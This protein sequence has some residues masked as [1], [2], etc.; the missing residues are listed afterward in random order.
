MGGWKLRILRACVAALGILGWAT[1]ASAQFTAESLSDDD[2]SQAIALLIEETM[3]DWDPQTHWDPPTPKYDHS[4]LGQTPLTILGLMHAGVKCQDPRLQPSVQWMLTASLQN[5]Y[6]V[7]CRAQAL[8]LMP[9][10]TRPELEQDIRWL[11]SSFGNK[12]ACWGY[13]AQPNTK[14]VDNSLR[15]YGALALWAGEQRGVQVPLAVWAALEDHLLREQRTDGGWGYTATDA[16][17]SSMTLAALTILAIAQ[18][19]LHSESAVRGNREALQRNQD[20]LQRGLDWVDQHFDPKSN[21]SVEKGGVHDHGWWWYH[22]YCVERVALATGRHRFGSH[23]WY[24]AIAA[25]MLELKFQR[26]GKKLVRNRHPLNAIDR[27]FALMFLSRGR[28]PVAINKLILDPQHTNR[29]PRD[30][31]NWTEHLVQTTEEK[32]NWQCVTLDDPL[33]KWIQSPL[34]W[35]TGQGRILQGS[36]GKSGQFQRAAH[37]HVAWRER[38]ARG[39]FPNRQAFLTAQAGLP[40]PPPHQLCQKMQAYLHDGGLLVASSDQRDRSFLASVRELGKKIYP[41]ASWETL[42][43]DHWIYS[44]HHKVR[45][46]YPVVEALSPGGRERILLFPNTDVSAALQQRDPHKVQL[47]QTLTNIYLGASGLQ[48]LPVRLH[49]VNINAVHHDPEMIP[50][51]LVIEAIHRGDWNPEPSSTNKLLAWMGHSRTIKVEQWPLADLDDLKQQAFV[52]VRGTDQTILTDQE[53]SALRSFVQ[54][55]RGV[56]LFETVHGEGSFCEL[57]EQQLR[58]ELDHPITKACD[59]PHLHSEFNAKLDE[60]GGVSF[61]YRTTRRI[62]SHDQSHRL[63]TMA[64]PNSAVKIFFSHEDLSYALLDRPWCNTN[65]YRTD[66][67]RLILHQ[68]MHGKPPE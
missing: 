3:K 31:A 28:V 20:A 42:P 24:R 19:W 56:I 53:L 43:Q 6:P 25:R 7:A 64:L 59:V 14:R 23:D 1:V 10:S 66:S 47:Y 9:E 34:L 16:P 33:G 29:R 30:A 61:Q 2:I 40:Q 26:K 67:A 50:E 11:L 46:Q 48:P 41:E 39:G 37:A 54:S 27:A 68:L 8:G 60:I 21:P 4:P 36:K 57:I 38:C 45:G 51:V 55:G 35:L 18:D 13:R 63:R 52:W 49:D 62:G 5:T 32:L 12:A 58:I 15:Q 65:G 17:R 44:L 22:A